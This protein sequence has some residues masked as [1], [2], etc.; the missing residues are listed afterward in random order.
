M[1]TFVYASAATVL[2]LWA[3]PYLAD[4]HG[5]PPVARGHVI[6]AMAAAQAAGTLVVGPLDLK[7]NTR[8]WIVVPGACCTIATRSNLAEPR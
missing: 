6:L 1:H 2:T 5:L 3:G 4:V 7:L 8:K